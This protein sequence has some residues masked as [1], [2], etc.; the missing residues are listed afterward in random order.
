MKFGIRSPKRTQVQ[1]RIVT[2]LGFLFLTLG[3][4]PVAAQPRPRPMRMRMVMTFPKDDKDIRSA[5]SAVKF[6]PPDRLELLDSD[7]KSSVR[8]IGQDYFMRGPD[9]TWLRVRKDTY[10]EMGK[11]LFTELA[12]NEIA[13]N[14]DRLSAGQM[15]L[16]GIVRLGTHRCRLYELNM[17]WNDPTEP[18]TL[19]GEKWVSIRSNLPLKA[20]FT[21]YAGNSNTPD[22][23]LTI[24]YQYDNRIR[25]SIP[26]M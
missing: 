23:V 6:S 7:G 21:V 20:Q 15:R 13:K 19:V 3:I 8:I 10:E 25:I 12:A 24:S 22:A 11:N 26:K 4:T 17:K 14:K 9:R 2:G 5:S 16:K 1:V 18:L